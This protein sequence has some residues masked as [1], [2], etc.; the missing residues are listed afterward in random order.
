MI[1]SA[2]FADAVLVDDATSIERIFLVGS[3]LA[4]LG[5]WAAQ[6]FV[7][8]STL[9]STIGHRILRIKVVRE[10]GGSPVGPLAGL[11]RTGLLALVLPA[12]FTD[13]TGRGYHDRTARTQLITT[14]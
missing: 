3:P 12:I 7:L 14:R 9:G 4:T 10:D 1:S 13:V 6:H 2:F 11:I 5:I 8:V